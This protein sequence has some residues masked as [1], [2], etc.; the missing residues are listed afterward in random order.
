MS[1]KVQWIFASCYYYLQQS[2]LSTTGC[3]AYT[4]KLHGFSKKKS[5]S[6][7]Q[8]S[9]THTCKK[10][11]SARYSFLVK[12]KF[13]PLCNVTLL[14]HSDQRRHPGTAHNL[15]SK[16]S[17]LYRKDHESRKAFRP[18]EEQWLTSLLMAEAAEEKVDVV[19][20]FWC[21]EI[22]IDIVAKWGRSLVFH[23][24][25]AISCLSTIQIASES[26]LPLRVSSAPFIRK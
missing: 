13:L 11:Q 2:S 18:S 4:Y 9:L 19:V 3:Y 1:L 25:K 5:C 16:I 20:T 7:L 8:I 24:V 22:I 14:M 15:Q 6:T 12:K 17:W 23:Q 26:L 10:Q 21:A